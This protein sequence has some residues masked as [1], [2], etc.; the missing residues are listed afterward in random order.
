MKMSYYKDQTPKEGKTDGFYFRLAWRPKGETRP[1]WTGPYRIEARDEQEA[2]DIL[3]S[4]S[5]RLQRSPGP[6]FEARFLHV[7]R[8]TFMTLDRYRKKYYQVQRLRDV[9]TVIERICFERKLKEQYPD[10]LPKYRSIDED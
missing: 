2:S 3:F 7:E 5:M 1:Q 10:G 4:V 9:E 8:H 6:F